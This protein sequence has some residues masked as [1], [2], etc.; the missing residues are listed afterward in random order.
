MTPQTTILLL[1]VNMPE[2]SSCIGPINSE[3]VNNPW[4]GELLVVNNPWGS[5]L[6]A[7]DLTR[8]SHINDCETF[9][10]LAFYIFLYL[11][12]LVMTSTLTGFVRWLAIDNETLTNDEY[13]ILEKWVCISAPLLYPCLLEKEPGLVC[14][15]PH[16]AELSHSA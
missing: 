13:R 2:S 5:P 15:R 6:E 14:W 3:I 9:M 1:S 12:P 16:G 8:H 7:R 10:I 4:G 11:C